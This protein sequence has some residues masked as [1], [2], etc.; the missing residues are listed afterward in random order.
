[1]NRESTDEKFTTF[2]QARGSL[3]S[4][5]RIL[6]VNWRNQN[7]AAAE[8]PVQFLKSFSQR[9]VLIRLL[10]S[11]CVHICAGRNLGRSQVLPGACMREAHRKRGTCWVQQPKT[12]VS[13]SIR[14][15]SAVCSTGGGGR[16]SGAWHRIFSQLWRV[17][18]SA[19]G[20]RSCAERPPSMPR[21]RTRGRTIFQR[22]PSRRDI[23]VVV[24]FTEY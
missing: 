16:Q 5:T 9:I 12:P 10:V 15:L 3:P 2:Y 7:H 11:R 6:F 21:H 17:D 19:R 18:E 14:C 13:N 8:N 1:M 23:H 20:A 22:S 24:V 4:I